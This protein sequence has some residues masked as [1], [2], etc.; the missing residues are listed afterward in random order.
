MEQNF[1]LCTPPLCPPGLPRRG[2]LRH[3][4]RGCRVKHPGF[5][6]PPRPPVT[7]NLDGGYLLSPHDRTGVVPPSL[8]NEGRSFFYLLY[9]ATSPRQKNERSTTTLNRS[10]FP[11]TPR[12]P[13]SPTFYKQYRDFVTTPHLT[14][15]R[16]FSARSPVYPESTFRRGRY[17]YIPR[18][19]RFRSSNFRQTPLCR[20]RFSVPPTMLECL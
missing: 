20:G 1:H 7:H 13:R 18:S 9:P 10:S 2:F 11:D 19:Q 8:R 3:A 15:K 4:T 14:P 17:P 16:R 6:L 5:T 12:C